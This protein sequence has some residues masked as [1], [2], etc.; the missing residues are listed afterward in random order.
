[1]KTH[2]IRET[3]AVRPAELFIF[4]AV[5]SLMLFNVP[6]SFR[7]FIRSI[8]TE[9]V[10]GAVTLVNQ[11]SEVRSQDYVVSQA[12]A[13]MTFDLPSDA[14]IMDDE[15]VT[16]STF[17]TE[18]LHLATVQPE[19]G[20]KLESWM[21]SD[22]FWEIPAL[23]H[24]GPAEASGTS[25]IR[26]DKPDL[27]YGKSEMEALFITAAEPFLE[28]EKWMTKEALWEPLGIAE[29]KEIQK[30]Y[31]DRKDIDY[32]AFFNRVR[33]NEML[34]AEEEKPLKLDAWMQDE[35]NFR[36]SAIRGE[37]LP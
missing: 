5:F 15:I 17:A 3:K 18:I 11:T 30:V 7:Q 1:M 24:A 16:S 22:E 4:L 37:K 28:L 36:T 10:N 20:L 6:E 9:T 32:Q 14:G 13:E 26:A 23:T 25:G 12:G 31:A 21:V 29:T 19:P 27:M 8:M 2:A 33:I 35:N 34:K